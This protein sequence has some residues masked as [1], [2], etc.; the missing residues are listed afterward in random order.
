AGS[1]QAA[2][3]K[4]ATTGCD[5]A[6]T[7]LDIKGASS[8]DYTTAVK[9]CLAVSKC[10][11]ISVWGVSDKDSWRTEF[12]PL[13]FD[14]NYQKKPAYTAVISAMS[15]SFALLDERGLILEQ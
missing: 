4:L 8:S 7:E 2:L 11:G 9:A 14:S 1:L 10:V 12:T 13:L 6:I 5:V 15:Q 3:T